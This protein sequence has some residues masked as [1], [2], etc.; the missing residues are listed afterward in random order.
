MFKGRV[1]AR[2]MIYLTSYIIEYSFNYIMK[3][4]Q[5]NFSNVGKVNKPYIKAQMLCQYTQLP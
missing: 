3:K 4:V 2:D 5:F 1:D